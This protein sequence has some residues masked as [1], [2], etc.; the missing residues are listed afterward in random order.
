MLAA[1]TEASQA[2]LHHVDIS[3]QIQQQ[4][5]GTAELVPGLT[6]SVYP[7]FFAKASKV[8]VHLLQV[9]RL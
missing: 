8:A 6:V 1:E 4:L 2:G 3:Q 5:A 9:R 7:D